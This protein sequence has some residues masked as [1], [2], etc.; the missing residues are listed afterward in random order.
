MAITA[1][2]TLPAQLHE[3]LGAWMLWTGMCLAVNASH[4]NATNSWSSAC[5]L[6]NHLRMQ[7][8]TGTLDPAK[9]AE[10]IDTISQLLDHQST[11]GIPSMQ[12]LVDEGTALA[13]WLREI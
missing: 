3:R 7:V 1:H 12:D 4:H 11:M 5:T 13:A 8:K 9:A 10:A 6:C 2:P